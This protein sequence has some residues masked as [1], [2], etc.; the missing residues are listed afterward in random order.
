[1]G[2]LLVV[3]SSVSFVNTCLI[4]VTNSDLLM[5][6]H[7]LWQGGIHCLLDNRLKAIVCEL[8]LVV[9]NY[10]LSVLTSCLLHTPG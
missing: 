6:G 3:L 5:L 1:M 10:S 9:M 4:L 2:I 7:T 8:G